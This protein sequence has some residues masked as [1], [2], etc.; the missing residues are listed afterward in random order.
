M[1][2]TAV[3]AVSCIRLF[4]ACPHKPDPAKIVSAQS[5]RKGIVVE[6]DLG[7]R[8]RDVN[9]SGGVIRQGTAFSALVVYAPRP[10][11]FLNYEQP[12]LL[13]ILTTF[14][15]TSRIAGSEYNQFHP[16][17]DLKRVYRQ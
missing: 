12:G 4:R 14:E 8:W 17:L 15:H 5:W 16:S 3:A 6:W 1:Q 10:C 2:N 13:A 7:R 9:S 11:A